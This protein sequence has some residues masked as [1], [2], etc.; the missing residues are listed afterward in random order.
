MINIIF[1]LL[2]ERQHYVL[3]PVFKPSSDAILIGMIKYITNNSFYFFFT[4]LCQQWLRRVI[5][6][7][8]HCENSN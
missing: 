7:I 1:I 4:D 8:T 5:R 3:F 2:L 6:L